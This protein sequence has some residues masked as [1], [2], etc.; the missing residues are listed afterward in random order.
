[1]NRPNIT[2]PAKVISIE[3]AREALGLG[4]GLGGGLGLGLGAVLA[5]VP[6]SAWTDEHAASAINR[7]LRTRGV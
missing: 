1:M 7:R 3:G 6:G 2:S 5:V 4:L